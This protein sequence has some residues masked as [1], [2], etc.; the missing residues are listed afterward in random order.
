[1]CIIYNCY[2]KIIITTLQSLKSRKKKFIAIK[3]DIPQ[4][5]NLTVTRHKNMSSGKH[6]FAS[7]TCHYVHVISIARL[8]LRYVKCNKSTTVIQWKPTGR[9]PLTHHDGITCLH[10]YACLRNYCKIIKLHWNFEYAHFFY[11]IITFV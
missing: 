2:Q 9:F 8:L 7:F 6:A 1:M 5:I 11:E 10:E 4:L 3:A